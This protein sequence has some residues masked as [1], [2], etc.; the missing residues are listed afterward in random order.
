MRWFCLIPLFL[1]ACRSAEDGKESTETVSTDD[2]DGDSFLS[3]EG[4]C[5]DG[6]PAINP[7][8]TDI[9]GDVSTPFSRVGYRT[10]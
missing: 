2:L 7:H 4:D 6:N 5:D 1:L 10:M 8:A 9:A 3:T